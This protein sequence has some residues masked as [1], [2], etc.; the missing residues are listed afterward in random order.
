MQSV[1]SYPSRMSDRK[2]V[3][4]VVK[5]RGKP[6]EVPKGQST[7]E[8]RANGQSVHLTNLEKVFWPE[9]SIT[10]GDLLQYYVDI[11]PFLLPHLANRAMVM[12][13]YPNGAY[14]KFFFQKHAPEP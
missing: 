4:P 13:R 8:I 12:K 3:D 1:R 9:S 7:A 14:G 6:V 11:S 2:S 5:K 10:K